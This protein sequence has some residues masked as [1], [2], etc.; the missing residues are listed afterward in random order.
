MPTLGVGVT[1]AVQNAL[2]SDITITA[3]TKASPASVTATAH[4]L[5]TGDIIKLNVAGMVELDEQAARITVVDPN[6]FTLD[7]IDSTGYSTFT[8]GVANEVTGFDTLGLAQSISVDEQSVD[9]IDITRLNS[10]QREITYGFLSPVK[11]SIG[12]LWEASDTA[13]VNLRAATKAKSARVFRVTF[14]DGSL[15]IFNA[16]VALGDAFQMD[17]GD[18][19]KATCSFTLQGRQIQFHAS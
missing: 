2:G 17:A 8:S 3:I 18:V 5:S 4:G 13:L 10:V 7:G 1:V 11:G 6:T 15:A 16:L 12:A 9:E 14:A 19:A